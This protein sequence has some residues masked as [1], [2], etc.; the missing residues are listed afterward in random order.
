MSLESRNYLVDITLIHLTLYLTCPRILIF[1]I[2]HLVS[3]YGMNMEQS[4]K[5]EMRTMFFDNWIIRCLNV[6]L[7]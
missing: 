5:Q 4:F 1:I 2:L 3:C 6:D 7:L